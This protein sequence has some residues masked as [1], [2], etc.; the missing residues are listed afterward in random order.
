MTIEEI[1]TKKQEAR[2]QINKILQTLADETD[3]HVDFI[4]NYEDVD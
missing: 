4:F 1:K 2:L 3:C